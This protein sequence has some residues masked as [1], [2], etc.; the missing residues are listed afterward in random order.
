MSNETEKMV[1][2]LGNNES[3]EISGGQNSAP[4]E[5]RIYVCHRPSF[6]HPITL[7]YG[8]LRPEVPEN[9]EEDVS[10]ITDDETND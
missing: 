10:L 5:E 8:A 3:A 9:Y 6:K 4:K 2:K 7:K 1:K